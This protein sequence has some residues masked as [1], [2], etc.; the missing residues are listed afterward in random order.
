MN[1]LLVIIIF[2]ICIYVCLS[3][4]CTPVSLYNQ[5]AGVNKNNELNNTEQYSTELSG[6]NLSRADNLEIY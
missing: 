3:M 6:N 4:T 2:V 5:S 1:K